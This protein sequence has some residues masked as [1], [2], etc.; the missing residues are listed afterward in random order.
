M[1][2]PIGPTV[3]PRR[4]PAIQKTIARPLLS[5]GMV[6]AIVAEPMVTGQLP[7]IPAMRRKTSRALKLLAT[8]QAIL[9]M[10]KTKL[11]T[12]YKGKRPYNSESGAIKRGPKT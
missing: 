6:S 11:H 5:I 4:G 3:G 8:A 2:I 7:A 12:L 9:K 1:L 10:K